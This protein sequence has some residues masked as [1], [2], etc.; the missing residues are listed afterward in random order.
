MIEKEAVQLAQKALDGD[1]KLPRLMTELVSGF[2]E[3]ATQLLRQMVAFL[4]TKRLP[5]R[6]ALEHPFFTSSSSPSTAS[7]STVAPSSSP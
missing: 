4:P 6:E 3:E 1:R 7:S 2:T 5:L